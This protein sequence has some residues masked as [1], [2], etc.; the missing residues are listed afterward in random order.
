MS[1]SGRMSRSSRFSMVS[2]LIRVRIG[3]GGWMRIGLRVGVREGGSGGSDGK[4]LL[5][6]DK[7]Y[8]ERPSSENMRR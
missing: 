7:R 1:R 4:R 2:R 8:R 3:A 6:K 5:L